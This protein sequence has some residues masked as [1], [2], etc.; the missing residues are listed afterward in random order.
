VIF[1]PIPRSPQLFLSPVPLGSKGLDRADSLNLFD[2]SARAS[3]YGALPTSKRYL[4][5]N[6]YDH[7]TVHGIQL[8]L[9]QKIHWSKNM[10]H[11]PKWVRS[12]EWLNPTRSNLFKEEFQIAREASTHDYFQPIN[13]YAWIDR[14]G[15]AQ[16]F[17]ETLAYLAPMHPSRAYHGG[18]AAWIAPPPSGSANAIFIVFGH[19]SS[20]QL[21]SVGGNYFTEPKCQAGPP[22]SSVEFFR[23]YDAFGHDE[24]GRDQRFQLVQDVVSRSISRKDEAY[25]RNVVAACEQFHTMPVFVTVLTSDDSFFHV[26]PAV[27][28][29][30]RPADFSKEFFGEVR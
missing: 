3:L 7:F 4:G 11:V 17:L 1:Q 16:L 28:E 13:L 8:Y 24:D 23:R 20:D 12:S 10:N 5:A 21:R 30:D 15:G 2:L 19:D 25:M 6:R 26:G 14:H 27:I 9:F 29:G 22:I 18:V